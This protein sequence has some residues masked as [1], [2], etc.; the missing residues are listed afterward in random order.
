MSKNDYHRY[1][2]NITL[3]HI[4]LS[5]R[6][7]LVRKNMLQ[8]V[9]HGSSFLKSSFVLIVSRSCSFIIFHIEINSSTLRR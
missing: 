1:L 4:E 3:E 2:Y 6:R 5:R 8:K 7:S 9:T